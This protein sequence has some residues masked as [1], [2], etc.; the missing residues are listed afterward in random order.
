M[1]EVRGKLIAGDMTRFADTI[2][3][4]GYVHHRPTDRQEIT[5]IFD[6][7]SQDPALDSLVAAIGDG[8]VRITIEPIDKSRRGER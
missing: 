5:L 1:I 2:A 7:E 6:V 8:M 3:I 4:N